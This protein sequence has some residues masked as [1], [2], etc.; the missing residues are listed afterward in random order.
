MLGPVTRKAS[1]GPSWLK[2]FIIISSVTSCC[3]RVSPWIVFGDIPAGVVPAVVFVADADADVD[4][5]E[6]G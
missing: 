1:E 5:D 4:V 3:V 6:A 2:K